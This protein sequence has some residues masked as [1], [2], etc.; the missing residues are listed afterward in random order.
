MSLAD[1]KYVSLTTYRRN[2]APKMTAVWIAPLGDGRMGFTTGADSFKVKRIRNNPAVLVQPCD[3]RGR[4]KDGTIP[5]PATATVVEG[6]EAA[7]VERA[8]KAKYGVQVTMI[9]LAEKARAMVGKRGAG[10]VSVVITL[11]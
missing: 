8:I 5:T 9:E 2:G 11:D 7:P 3:M 6:A 1:E 10:T 4:L